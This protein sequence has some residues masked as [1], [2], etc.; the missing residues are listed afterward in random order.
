MKTNRFVLYFF[1]SVLACAFAV[2]AGRAS[3]LTLAGNALSFDGTGG[4]VQIGR[5]D[6]RP[7]WTAVRWSLRKIR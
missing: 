5:A 7:P 3:A 1:R 6:L 2:A 4:S